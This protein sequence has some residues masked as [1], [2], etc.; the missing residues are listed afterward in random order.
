MDMGAGNNPGGVFVLSKGMMFVDGNAPFVYSGVITESLDSAYMKTIT[1]V[2]NFSNY[3][4]PT[5]DTV[6]GLDNYVGTISTR[7]YLV[8]AFAQN[9]RF[10]RLGFL[11]LP[12]NGRRARVTLYAGQG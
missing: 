2:V 11:V 3:N 7:K 1:P 5:A 4:P 12:P 6:L 9:T 8:T 10:F